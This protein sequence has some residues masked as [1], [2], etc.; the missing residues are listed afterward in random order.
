MGFGGS[1]PRLAGCA[2]NG[3]G[4]VGAAAEPVG[5]SFALASPVRAA[6][7][8]ASNGRA[9]VFGFPFTVA[10]TFASTLPTTGWHGYF[11]RIAA[12]PQK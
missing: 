2:G 10:F 12:T 7:G 11:A 5:V 6:A 9:F 3:G 4:P 1:S 8:R